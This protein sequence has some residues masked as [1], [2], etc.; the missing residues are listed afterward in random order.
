MVM[1]FLP[2]IQGFLILR[3]LYALFLS[4]LVAIFT[5]NYMKVMLTVN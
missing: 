3:Y 2:E 1:G 5:I 4:L